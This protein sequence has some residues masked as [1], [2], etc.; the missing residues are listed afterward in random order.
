MKNKSFLVFAI[1]LIALMVGVIGCGEPKVDDRAPKQVINTYLEGFRDK[2]P[3]KIYKTVSAETYRGLQVPGTVDSIFRDQ[4][5]VSGDIQN[6]QLIG[7]PYIDEVNNQAMIKVLV[8]ATKA[9]FTLEFDLRR[10]GN[11][12]YMYGVEQVMASNKVKNKKAD[13]KNF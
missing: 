13:P 5:R 10:T 4:S 8:K 2:N 7:E 3:E 9:T 6:W 12:W 1:G 11:Q